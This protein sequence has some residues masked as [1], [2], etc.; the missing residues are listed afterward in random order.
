MKRQVDWGSHPSRQRPDQNPHILK[1]YKE[2]EHSP[3]WSIAPYVDSLLIWPSLIRAYI[4]FLWTTFMQAN[5]A[6]TLN[7]IP[8]CRNS[9]HGQ[10]CLAI[11]IPT[12]NPNIW[13]YRK[14][15]KKNTALQS[16]T[17]DQQWSKSQVH[18]DQTLTSPPETTAKPAR[19]GRTTA[20]RCGWRTTS[21]DWRV[22]DYRQWWPSRAAEQETC[23]TWTPLPWGEAKKKKI[24]ISEW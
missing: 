20:Q 21:D 24:D 10:P 19:D 8:Q 15:K 23:C 17:V 7:S 18:F 14:K 4:R 2:L 3:I 13:C 16:H 1:R 11:I 12:V 5:M 6:C 9:I 22:P